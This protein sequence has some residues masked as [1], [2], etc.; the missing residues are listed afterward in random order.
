MITTEIKQLVKEL[1]PIVGHDVYL[2]DCGNTEDCPPELTEVTVSDL[3]DVYGF[4]DDNIE[5]SPWG[6]EIFRLWMSLAGVISTMATHTVQFQVVEP[7]RGQ[8]ALWEPDSW[9]VAG[10]E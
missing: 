4:N 2:C 5:Q 3:Y 8:G 10:D 6:E 1:D 7:I 9:K